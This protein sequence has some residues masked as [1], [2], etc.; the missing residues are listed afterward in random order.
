MPCPEL[1]LPNLIDYRSFSQPPIMDPLTIFGFASVTIMLISYALERRSRVW[2]LIFAI[3]CLSSALY[4]FLAGTL[5]FTI[6]ETIWA[7]VALMRWKGT[8]PT[9]D[10]NI[11]KL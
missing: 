8:K 5:P 2:I 10:S 7:G 9:V 6:V 11:S 3:A 1:I 4:A